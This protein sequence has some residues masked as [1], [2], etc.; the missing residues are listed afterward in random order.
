MADVWE[1]QEITGGVCT[2]KARSGCR[3]KLEKLDDVTVTLLR[4]RMARSGVVEQPWLTL[5][6]RKAPS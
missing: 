6:L 3:G 2:Q 4:E 1:G 5:V